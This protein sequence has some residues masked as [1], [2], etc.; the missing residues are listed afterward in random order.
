MQQEILNIMFTLK[1]AAEKKG[2][3]CKFV[4]MSP[5]PVLCG[6]CHVVPFNG[7]MMPMA[8][9]P[10]TSYFLQIKDNVGEKKIETI[11]QVEKVAKVTKVIKVEV[12]GKKRKRHLSAEDKM[13]T[14]KRPRGSS[15]ATLLGSCIIAGCGRPAIISLCRNTD[16]YVMHTYYCQRHAITIDST[17]PSCHS[18]GGP[19]D[20]APAGN[21]EAAASLLALASHCSSSSSSSHP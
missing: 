8:N 6:V 18:D 19:A 13:V 14:N 12:A 21:G 17:C 3:A 9:S 2:I 10:F 5:P 11:K 4:E 15:T 20:A 7:M 1:R 16:N